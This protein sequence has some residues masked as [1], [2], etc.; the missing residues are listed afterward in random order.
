MNVEISDQVAMQIQ[1]IVGHSD[2]S[3][4]EK[5][6]ERVAGDEH[7]LRALV[8]DDRTEHEIR[9][10]AE[11]C[12]RGMENIRAGNCEPLDQAMRSIADDSGF[13]VKR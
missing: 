7:L 11:Q 5:I 13:D 1:A 9:A 4:I 3:L 10:S 8:L 2:K 12:E 6:L